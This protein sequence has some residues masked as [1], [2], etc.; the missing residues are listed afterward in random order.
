MTL[1]MSDPEMMPTPPEAAPALPGPDRESD[2]SELRS[3]GAILDALDH[4]ARHDSVSVGDVL[5]EIGVTSFA[6]IL[7]VPAMILVSPLSGIP[8][9]PTIG[10]ML[11]LLISV[12]KLLGR[13]HIWL[14]GWLKRRKVAGWRLAKATTWLRRPAGWIDRRTHRRLPWLVSRPANV[15]TLA[16]ILVICLLIPFLEILPMVTSIFATAIAFYAIALLARDGVFTLLGHIWSGVALFGI[17]W[18]VSGGALG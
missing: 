5:E 10:A 13:P 16:T 7:L 15:L 3:L 12:Q 18:L 14:P 4:T 1:T 2:G 8:G 11:M 9:L 17:W 6:P